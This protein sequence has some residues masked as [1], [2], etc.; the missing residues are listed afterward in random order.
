MFCKKHDTSIAT[1]FNQH[2]Q[3]T[4]NQKKYP[5]K[6]V[7]G[8]VVGDAYWLHFRVQS[9]PKWKT[10]HINAPFFMELFP[11]Q[12]NILTFQYGK[13]KRFER[14]TVKKKTCILEF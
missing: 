9:I 2:F 8:R 14:L 7:K 12:S 1:Y 11:N 6:F 4:I 3:L 13:I 10:V 5:L